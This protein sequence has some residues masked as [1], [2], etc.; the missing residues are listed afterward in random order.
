MDGKGAQI[1]R[2]V[3]KASAISVDMFVFSHYR[4]FRSLSAAINKNVTKSFF[5]G[6]IYK[7]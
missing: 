2:T 7:E 4:R 5:I 3:S 1:R 6:S